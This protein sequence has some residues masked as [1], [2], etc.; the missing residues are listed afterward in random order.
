MILVLLLSIGI[1]CAALAWSIV[2]LHRLRDMRMAVLTL[3]TALA[4]MR[5]GP[6]LIRLGG[7]EAGWMSDPGPCCRSCARYL[8]T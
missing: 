3:M 7:S 1:R 2:L 4:A 6:T 5:Q 8:T